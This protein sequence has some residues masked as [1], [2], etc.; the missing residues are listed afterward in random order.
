MPKYCWYSPGY[1]KPC[2]YYY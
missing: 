1:Y 2:S